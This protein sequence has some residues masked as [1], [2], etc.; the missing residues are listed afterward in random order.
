MSKMRVLSSRIMLF[1][2]VGIVAIPLTCHPSTAYVV[3]YYANTN[4][5]TL[6]GTNIWFL[7]YEYPYLYAPD[8]S[9]QKILVF[10]SNFNIVNNITGFV[11]PRGIVVEGDLMYVTDAGTNNLSVLENG[12]L[13]NSTSVTGIRGI[14]IDSQG[15]ILV[16]SNILNEV[17][18][19]TPNFTLVETLS[20]FGPEG[21]AVGPDGRIHVAS[22]VSDNVSLFTPSYDMIMTYGALYNPYDIDVNINGYILVIDYSNDRIQI[23]SP[24]LQVLGY[25]TGFSGPFSLVTDGVGRLFVY[26]SIDEELTTWDTGDLGD[27]D[28]PII[29]DVTLTPL[30]PIAGQNVTVTVTITDLTGIY[31]ATLNYVL[32]S[33]NT[34]LVMTRSG[35][36]FSA[37]IP[38]Q[39]ANTVVNFT[40]TAAD[41][42][43]AHWE[44]TS[45][46]YQYNVQV[47]PSLLPVDP[48]LLGIAGVGV[49]V[50]AIVVALMGRSNGGR[51][52]KR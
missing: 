2:L 20:V 5:V 52:R 45:M 6:P 19:F 18:V 25:I 10:D 51:K 14:A 11:S 24:D 9:L 33:G 17:Y 29:T 50:I 30:N 1:V 47:G 28:G 15:N 4:T 49:G 34:T 23:L 7:N 41:S 43:Y 21:I 22:L 26:D 40:I 3:P 27:Y 38:G 46:V 39:P 13:T 31:N 48:S 32:P 42:T 12:I 37:V 36:T 8:A 44:T 35:S 16:S